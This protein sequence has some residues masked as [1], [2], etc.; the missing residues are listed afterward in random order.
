[1]AAENALKPRHR[2]YS[3]E[4]W[5]FAFTIIVALFHLELFYQKKLMP[6]GTST[7][8]FFFIL[9]GFTIAMSAAGRVESGGPRELSTRESGAL[10]MDYLK[11]KFVAIYPV[12]AITL[13]VILI[14]IPLTGMSFMPAYGAPSAGFFATLANGFKALLSS[15]WEWLM[16]VGTPMGFNDASSAAAPLVPLWFLTQLLVFGYL[17]TFLANRKYDLMMFA[18][19][20]ISVFGFAFFVMNSEHN[21]DF[22]VK[23]GFLNAGAIR[24]MTH[25][26]MGFSIYR[27]YTFIINREWT[28]FG[29][30]ALQLLEVY[31]IWRYCS[32]VFGAQLSIDNFRRIP[33]ILVIVLLSFSNVTLLSKALNRKFMEKL[34]KITLPIYL[35]H[36][37]V[38]TVYVNLM[39]RLKRSSIAPRLP[40]FMIRSAGTASWYTIIGMSI[41]DL[42][43]YIPFVIISAIAMIAL[44]RAVSRLSRRLG[45]SRK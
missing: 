28:L 14:V 31:S 15:E 26:A 21:L 42:V 6:S 44:V 5:R 45:G 18:A 17:Y 2:V 34:G 24:A 19:P 8:E 20:L 25:M 12:L 23:M 10:A 7:V 11:K 9:A 41:G 38:A 43:M 16:L 39:Y 32:L 22:Y 40:Q 29:K 1:M 13:V 33:H 37:P 36:F 30:I 35:I 4:F 27:I 3:V